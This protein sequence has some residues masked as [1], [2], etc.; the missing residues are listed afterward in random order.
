MRIQD[1]RNGI[2]I[3]RRR[4]MGDV[5]RTLC[6]TSGMPRGSWRARH[7]DSFSDRHREAPYCYVAVPSLYSMLDPFLRAPSWVQQMLDADESS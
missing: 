7:S 6:A 4:E 2:V 5:F 3:A 1:T